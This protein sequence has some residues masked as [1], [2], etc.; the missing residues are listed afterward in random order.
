MSSAQAAISSS[1]PG[2]RSFTTVYGIDADGAVLVRP[3]GHVAFRSKSG[4]GA[5]R[6]LCEALGHLLSPEAAVAAAPRKDRRPQ[7]NWLS[8]ARREHA[9]DE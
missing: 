3:D 1:V 9:Y 4:L 7:K 8:E 5:A 6:A 2:E